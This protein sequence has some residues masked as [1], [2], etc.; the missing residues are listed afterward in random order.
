M[1][2]LSPAKRKTSI[3]PVQIPKHVDEIA[4]SSDELPSDDNGQAGIG[5][6]WD[7][8]HTDFQEF[9]FVIGLTNNTD[10]TTLWTSPTAEILGENLLH[11]SDFEEVSSA[12]M[13]QQLPLCDP[14]QSLPF[15]PLASDEEKW[16]VSND[17]FF[18]ALQ[19]AASLLEP[20]Q[21]DPD[22]PFKA[23]LS[24]WHTIDPRERDKPIWIMLRLIDERVFGLW[25]SKPQK[26]ALMYVIH[27][28]VKV[29]FGGH[30]RLVKI[31]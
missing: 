31:G 27:T 2:A 30:N 5:S 13:H 12:T 8:S 24:G 3:A 11:P 28:L 16:D 10:P 7:G 15:L 26:I 9:D 14:F 21:V 22:V 18:R 17:A 20:D 19:S 25:T 23:I 4:S 1:V 29:G 6:G